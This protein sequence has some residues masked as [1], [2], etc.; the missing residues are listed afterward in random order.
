MQEV[1]KLNTPVRWYETTTPQFWNNIACT[2][3]QF[4]LLCDKRAIL[5]WVYQ[6][7][8]ST[9]RVS[10][11]CISWLQSCPTWFRVFLCLSVICLFVL[12]VCNIC[13]NMRLWFDVTSRRGTFAKRWHNSE[14]GRGSILTLLS[15]IFYKIIAFQ[16]KSD[17]MDWRSGL[18]D[19]QTL[20]QEMNNPPE[21]RRLLLVVNNHSCPAENRDWKYSL[22]SWL[23]C[24]IFINENKNGSSI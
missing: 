4:S 14:E 2:W 24:P 15:F 17:N 1:G 20:V 10:L 21:S 23:A 11:S 13:W 16:D 12:F 5:A 6:S 7:G 8:R 3:L 9:V 19:W 18:R 22:F